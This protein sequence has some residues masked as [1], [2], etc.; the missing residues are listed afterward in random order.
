MLRSNWRCWDDWLRGYRTWRRR[1]TR[2]GRRIT[3][4]IA[5]PP[6]WNASGRTTAPGG[7]V[8]WRRAA[9]MTGCSLRGRM[10]KSVVRMSLVQ[11]ASWIRRFAC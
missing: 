3:A 2:S 10:R 1:T 7:C 9:V 6:C 8:G 4:P 11:R 5:W